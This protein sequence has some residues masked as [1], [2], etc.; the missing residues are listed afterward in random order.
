MDGIALLR[1]Y[2]AY[3]RAWHHFMKMTSSASWHH[4]FINGLVCML[5]DERPPGILI[6][7]MRMAVDLNPGWPAVWML[8][9]R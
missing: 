9:T 2:L 3:E 6:A 5:N 8:K 4:E 1:R 7:V